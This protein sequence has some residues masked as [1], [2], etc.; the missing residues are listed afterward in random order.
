MTERER[1][2]ERERER[3]REKIGNGGSVAPGSRTLIKLMK[4]FLQSY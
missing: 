4:V 3:K 1:A 2:N